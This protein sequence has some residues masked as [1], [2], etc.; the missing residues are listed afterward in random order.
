MRAPDLRK[1]DLRTQRGRV[2]R[3]LRRAGG[4]RRRLTRVTERHAGGLAL[5]SRIETQQAS[6]G[7]STQPRTIRGA[8]SS[9]G[10]GEQVGVQGARVPEAVPPSARLI[11]PAVAPIGRGAH[12]HDRRA[13]R[14]I[15]PMPPPAAAPVALAQPCQR[16]VVR[17]EM[18]GARRERPEVA[19][20]EVQ[21]HVVERARVRVGAEVDLST[22]VTLPLGDPGREQEHARECRELRAARIARPAV[23]DERLASAVSAGTTDSGNSS[24]EGSDRDPDRS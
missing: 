6:T 3:R 4:R 10:D 24:G 21:I 19:R 20:H 2:A 11:L 12:H 15:R 13:R 9:V 16:E 18:I 1:V 22:W 7:P 17:A 5:A 8:S 23:A 14:G